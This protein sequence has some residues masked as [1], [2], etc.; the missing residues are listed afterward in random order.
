METLQFEGD[1]SV[2]KKR[3][4][5]VIASLRNNCELG[6]ATKRQIARLETIFRP[7]LNDDWKRFL[8]M[9]SDHKLD[10]IP[11]LWAS[12]LIRWSSKES[13]ANDF[14]AVRDLFYLRSSD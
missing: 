13:F 8:F 11:A 5:K 4:L 6:Y 2:D 10:D 7:L 3:A 12:Q 14:E 9:L 1:A